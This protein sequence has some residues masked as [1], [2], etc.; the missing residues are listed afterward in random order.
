VEAGS[1]GPACRLAKPIHAVPSITPSPRE[2][3][4]DGPT[5]AP[6][7]RLDEPKNGVAVVLAGVRIA[8]KSRLDED[9]ALGRHDEDGPQR[10]VVGRRRL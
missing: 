6:A 2:R 9:E 5:G 4:G 10:H 8:L 7:L 1:A 3:I